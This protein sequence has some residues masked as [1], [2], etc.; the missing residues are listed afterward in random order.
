MDCVTDAYV[1]LGHQWCCV[2][3]PGVENM[4]IRLCVGIYIYS[5]TNG[6]STINLVNQVYAVP[7]LYSVGLRIFQKNSKTAGHQKLLYILDFVS[8]LTVYK[9][10][11]RK[12]P[13]LE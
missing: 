5:I 6:N 13:E 12:F 9:I 11:T 3:L 2:T 1:T 7:F 8:E 4:L 10:N